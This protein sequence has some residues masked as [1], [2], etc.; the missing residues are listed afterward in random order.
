MHAI[1]IRYF[2]MLRE[3]AQVSEE[4]L[5][6]SA[7]TYADLYQ[8]LNQRYDFGLPPRMVQV[9]VN[10]E[11]MSLDSKIIPNSSVVFIPPVAGG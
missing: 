10:D 2:A 8:E 5:E 4:Q 9:A 3:K 1:K 6:T 7:V 11:F